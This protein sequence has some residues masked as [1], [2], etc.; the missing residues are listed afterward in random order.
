[1]DHKK[2]ISEGKYKFY[3][4]SERDIPDLVAF[5]QNNFLDYEPIMRNIGIMEGTSILDRYLRIEMCKRLVTDLII[6][7]GG[8]P[9]CVVA[10]STVDDSILGCRMGKVV[11]R[12]E[13]RNKSEPHLSCVGNLLS[14]LPI[15]LKSNHMLNMKRLYKDLK[16]G[17]AYAFK[18][19]KDANKIYFA[20]NVCVSAKSRGLGLGSE[21][22]RRGYTIA[23]QYGC[24]YTYI[25]ASSMYSQH[26]FHKLG[27]CQI[28][29]QVRY[30]DYRFDKHG[31][32]FL[33]NTNEHKVIQVVA[34]RHLKD[35][36]YG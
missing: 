18:E 9:S 19:L 35:S 31:R 36:M 1:M 22:V 21:L 26:K 6:H 33:I 16:Y 15:P 23:K 13:A 3:I 5:V 4:A 25:L 32:P 7:A 28:L 14:Y 34:I 10:R 30:K 2:W 17:Q 29:H 8:T 24:D 12:K 27:N 20:S 11:S